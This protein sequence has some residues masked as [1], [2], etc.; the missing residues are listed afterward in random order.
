[1]KCIWETRATG[2]KHFIICIE[3]STSF[4]HI[5]THSYWFKE[6][7]K[8]GQAHNLYSPH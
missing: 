1:M 8:A 7:I 3:M 4:M 6:E 5:Y 2:K